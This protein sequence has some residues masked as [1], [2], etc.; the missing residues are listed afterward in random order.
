MD[1]CS[2]FTVDAVGQKVTVS[3]KKL[4][5]KTDATE[6]FG[7][8][9][10]RGGNSSDMLMQ[11]SGGKD[12]L[13]VVATKSGGNLGDTDQKELEDLVNKV[14]QKA[15]SNAT[16]GATSGSTSSSSGT[17]STSTATVTSTPSSSSSS[18]SST[19][20]ASMS[21]TPSSSSSR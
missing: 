3:S 18:G 17:T 14:L 6:T 4:Q 8:V 9:S 7:T 19:S 20:G 1:K 10:T 12:R 21:A 15:S 11:V 5:A 13:L 16:S 2:T